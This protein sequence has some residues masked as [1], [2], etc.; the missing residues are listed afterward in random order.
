[1][2]AVP[3]VE[4]RC[5]GARA[6]AYVACPN[7]RCPTYGRTTASVVH[8][9]LDDGSPF[10]ARCATCGADVLALDA[11]HRA[12]LNAYAAALR[13]EFRQPPQP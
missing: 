2:A 11:E 5:D 3:P 8:E 6:V 4:F 10:L 1:M 13:I 7:D 12:S 9:L